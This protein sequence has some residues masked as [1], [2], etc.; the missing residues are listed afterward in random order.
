MS[1]PLVLGFDLRNTTR[2]DRA[3]PIISNH[4]AMSVSQSWEAA[5]PDPSGSLIKSWQ[6]QTKASVVV[7]CG[8]GCPCKDRNENCAKWAGEGQCTANPGYMHAECAASCPNTMNATGWKIA[9]KT[10][11]TPS[12]DCLDAAG[13]LTPAPGSGL[14][15]LR[16]AACDA[17]SETQR[18][19]YDNGEPR[20]SGLH[21]H[22]RVRAAT[23]RC[24][25]ARCARS[26][27]GSA[28]A[29]RA[30][31]CGRSRWSR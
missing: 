29:C 26:R 16:T 7:G 4:R 22:E 2:L 13:Q 31:G 18:W 1:A 20:P 17:T 25:Q 6:D 11:T 10:V 15:W 5:R 21:H 27:R 8:G 12:G 3:W 9:G 24:E 23:H 19:A 30:T 14:N 28:S